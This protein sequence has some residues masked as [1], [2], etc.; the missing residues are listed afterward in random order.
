[1]AAGAVFLS[2][3]E[4]TPGAED[5]EAAM[6]GPSK[7]GAPGCAVPEAAASPPMSAVIRG[8]RAAR[9]C[10]SACPSPLREPLIWAAQDVHAQEAKNSANAKTGAM[11]E[12][13][14]A[15]L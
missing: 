10:K 6:A 12:L 8:S 2:D 7:I 13:F 4:A 5:M 14:M 9:I 11:T 1:M 15:L 3:T